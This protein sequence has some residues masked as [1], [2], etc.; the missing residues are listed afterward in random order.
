MKI[1]LNTETDE[2]EVVIT[3]EELEKLAGEVFYSCETGEPMFME[4]PA[5]EKMMQEIM[6]GISNV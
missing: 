6:E 3:L 4:G 1:V 2:L 5:S